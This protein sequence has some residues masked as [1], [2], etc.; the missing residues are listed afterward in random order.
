MV[1]KPALRSNIVSSMLMIGLLHSTNGPG[2]GSNRFVEVGELLLSDQAIWCQPLKMW[3]FARVVG[4][5]AHGIS[6]LACRQATYPVVGH[7]A[8]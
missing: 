4:I 1:A 5:L 6:K 2:Q 8:L 3:L 7:M